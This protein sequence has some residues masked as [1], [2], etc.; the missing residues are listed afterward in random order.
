MPK[1][2]KAKVNE[3]NLPDI[4]ED[5]HPTTDG[6]EVNENAYEQSNFSSDSESN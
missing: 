5:P 1:D 2:R 4:S 6:E 3:G